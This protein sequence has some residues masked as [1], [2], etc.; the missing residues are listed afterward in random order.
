MAILK[1]TD[2]IEARQREIAKEIARLQEESNELAIAL[3]VIERLY[4]D[5]PAP[6]KTLPKA[7]DTEPS[8]KAETTK[9]GPSLRLHS[10]LGSDVRS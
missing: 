8:E 5:S 7:P 4:S 1:L 3:R 10:F 2:R 6:Q 9:L